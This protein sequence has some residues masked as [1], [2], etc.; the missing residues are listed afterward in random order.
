MFYKRRSSI[1]SSSLVEETIITKTVNPRICTMPRG[2]ASQTIV[3]YK[4]K[5]DDFIVFVESRQMV[6]AWKKDKSVPLAQVMQ[7]WKVFVTH[8]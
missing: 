8:K 5:V 1:K 3:H 7:G 6:E 4:G 2:N